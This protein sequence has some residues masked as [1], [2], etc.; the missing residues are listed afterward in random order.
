MQAEATSPPGPLAPS[1]EDID[2]DSFTVPP[3]AQFEEGGMGREEGECKVNALSHLA[4]SALTCLSNDH[5]SDDAL[6]PA[7]AECLLL[8]S[9]TCSYSDGPPSLP[10]R[11]EPHQTKQY[12]GS[13]QALYHESPPSR[14]FNLA[15]LPS[16][17]Q[18]LSH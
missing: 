12:L 7:A 16:A 5:A 1:S 17:A 10:A 9:C 18:A 13:D 4:K 2:S 8:T 6:S 11:P 15:T 3:V 14:L